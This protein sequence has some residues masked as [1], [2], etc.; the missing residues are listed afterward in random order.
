METG[1]TS[2]Y[3]KYAIG[4]II[5]V[6]IGILIALQINNWN[7]QRKTD[8]QVEELFSKAFQELEHN[9]NQGRRLVKFYRKKGNQFNKVLNN[10]L[11]ASEIEKSKHNL[12]NWGAM[13]NFRTFDMYTSASDNLFTF[14]TSV[15]P[16]LKELINKLD[17]LYKWTKPAF[18]DLD[19]EVEIVVD[20]H[21]AFARDNK[22]WFHKPDHP[23]FMDDLLTYIP[24]S[25]THLTLP[26]IYSV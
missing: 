6:V 9:L 20:D 17:S 8:K 13:G 4:E 15:K 2:K 12:E 21:S 23:L 11:S 5:L 3:L 14:N 26:T 10:T 25:Y 1:K 22:P 18:D 16:E 24:V 7:E 19:E